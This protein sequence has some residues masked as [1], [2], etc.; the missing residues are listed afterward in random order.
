MKTVDDPC[1]PMRSTARSLVLACCV[2][3]VIVT[4]AC[5]SATESMWWVELVRYAP[6]PVHLIPVSLALGLSLYLGWAYRIC[7][8]VALVLVGTQV[9]G[10][11]WGTPDTGTGALRVMTYNVKAYLAAERADG[12]DHLAGEIA[13]H[14]PDVLVMQDAFDVVE[15]LSAEQIP[16][17]MSTLRAALHGRQLYGSGE[18]L[19]A[20]RFPLRDC[21]PR[22]MSYRQQHNHY[23]VC[24][25]DVRGVPI[26]I[27]TAHFVSPR[28]GLNA[29]R[30]EYWRGLAEWKSNYL[31]RLAQAKALSS[32]VA[33][34]S[35]AVIVAGDLNADEQSP[36]VRKL[37]ATGLRDAF[38]SAGRGYGFTHGHSLRPGFSFLRIDHILVSP[39]VGVRRCYTGGKDASEHRPVVA[40]LLTLP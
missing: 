10:L 33:S 3:A 16:A 9:T 21:G 36:V 4:L 13:K 22:D 11:K 12:F 34:A 25:M 29:A 1:K 15:Q 28:E 20:S 31:N 37:L 24:T 19:V 8:F 17:S 23:V 26:D 39:S 18:Y 32:A 7:A 14:D 35:H 6:F 5:E 2:G 40:D 38:A 27:F 30:F